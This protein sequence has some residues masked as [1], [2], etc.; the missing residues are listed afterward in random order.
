MARVAGLVLAAGASRR[1]GE[2]KQLLVD[3]ES[4][5]TMVARAAQQLLT[6]GCSPV[7]VVTGAEHKR[8]EEALVGM[9]VST[10]F[11][12][13]WS[14]GMGSSISRGVQWLSS[15]NQQLDAVMIV[16]CDMP[17]VDV[18]HLAS[19]LATSESGERRVAS[20]Y[21]DSTGRSIVGTPAIFPI[22][23]WAQLIELSGDRGAR[24]LL[25]ANDTLS[26]FL[27]MGQFDLDTPEDVSRWRIGDISDS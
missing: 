13:R 23:E 24:S 7:V 5:L 15:L 9:L 19:L 17:T 25:V 26:V 18:P 4:R 8:V 6:V 14:E 1:L 10:C 2:P 20:A 11:N 22:K 3:A 12:D 27:R 16:P 21:E